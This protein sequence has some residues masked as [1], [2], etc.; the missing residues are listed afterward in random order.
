MMGFSSFLW[1]SGLLFFSISFNSVRAFQLPRAT[2]ENCL[3]SDKS[4]EYKKSSQHRY[5]LTDPGGV[6]PNWRPLTDE[7]KGDADPLVCSGYGNADLDSKQLVMSATCEDC[8]RGFLDL[9]KP[10]LVG[11]V[12]RAHRQC[13]NGLYLTYYSFDFTR[14]ETCQTICQCIRK[15]TVHDQYKPDRAKKLPVICFYT[16]FPVPLYPSDNDCE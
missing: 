4:E 3:A 2:C 13:C 16:P 15:I 5:L 9:C 10:Y 6:P 14:H 7:E 1:V 8:V 11:E 12:D